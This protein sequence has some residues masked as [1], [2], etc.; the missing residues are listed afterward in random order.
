MSAVLGALNVIEETCQNSEDPHLS[1][2]VEIAGHGA[3]R[4]LRLVEAMLDITRLETGQEQATLDSVNLE[5]LTNEVVGEFASQCR[6]YGIALQNTISEDCLSVQ[7]DALKVSRILANL[8][9]NA[10]KFTPRDGEINIS[11]SLVGD[12]VHIY[13]RD[14][15]PGIPSEYGEKIF[16]RFSQVPGQVG[17]RRGSGLGL[18]FCKLAAESQ[19]GRI[20]VE[21][22]PEGGSRFVFTLRKV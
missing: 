20:W 9:D 2:A 6:N 13:V 12:E 11:T 5:L 4:A 17:R 22:P 18:A 21:K 16:E 10:V 19:G 3:Q 15:G 14:T 7:A 8:L 1:R